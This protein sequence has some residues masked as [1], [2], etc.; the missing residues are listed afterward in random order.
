MGTTLVVIMAL[1]LALWAWSAA[2]VAQERAMAAVRL[3]L[4]GSGAQLL[5]GTVALAG[6]RV[7]RNRRGRVSLS[8]TY[9]FD[10]SRDGMSRETGNMTLTGDNI[11]VIDLPSLSAGRGLSS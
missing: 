2:R 1:G 5:D 6:V 4:R 3:L 9:S 7:C 10:V 11:E 8:R